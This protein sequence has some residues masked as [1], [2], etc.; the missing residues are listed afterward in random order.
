M[1]EATDALVDRHLKSGWWGLLLF[2][3][4]GGVLE[5][6]HAFKLGFYLDVGNE[7]R[8]ML[9]TLAHAHGALLSILQLAFAA[10]LPLSPGWSG[11]GREW[12]SRGLLAALVLVPGGFLLG[13]LFSHDGD[14]GLGILLLPAGLVLLFSAV[15]LSARAASRRRAGQ[16]ADSPPPA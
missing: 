6:L 5:I 3:S 10:T 8:R 14:P 12:A 9:L 16:R 2:L 4:L 7:A 11:P 13:G 1:D 15:L